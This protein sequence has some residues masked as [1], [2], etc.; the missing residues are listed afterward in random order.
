M[1]ICTIFFRFF[2]H[3]MGIFVRF[4]E[5]FWNISTFLQE[6]NKTYENSIGN[7]MI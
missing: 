1:H 4:G 3:I 5:L 2:G 6:D 7:E